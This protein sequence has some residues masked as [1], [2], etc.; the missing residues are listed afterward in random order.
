MVINIGLFFNTLQEKDNNPNHA[1]SNANPV[2]AGYFPQF[3]ANAGI[4]HATA[5]KTAAT[6]P[7][8]EFPVITSVR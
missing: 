1:G 6:K 2:I 3:A 8:V 4:L 5:A 7:A